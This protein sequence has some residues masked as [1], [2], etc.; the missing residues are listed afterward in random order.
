MSYQTG[1][2]HKLQRW[3]LCKNLY[4]PTKENQ[5]SKSLHFAILPS[6]RL[7]QEHP[8]KKGNANVSSKPKRLPE[9]I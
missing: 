9:K 2:F 8:E 1:T 4:E 6:I 3:Q 7:V 5:K